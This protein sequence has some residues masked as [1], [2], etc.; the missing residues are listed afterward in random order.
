MKEKLIEFLHSFTVYDYIYLGGV[1]FIFILLIILTL[2]LRTKPALSLF[3]LLLAILDIFLASTLGLD[4]FHNYM[5]K[6]S[7]KVTKAKRL[8]FVEAVVIEGSLKNESKFDFS[9]CK[10][11]AKI[12]KDTHNKY[13]NMIFKLKPIKVESIKLNNIAKDADVKFKFLIEPF[14]YKKDFNVSV[15]GM[16]K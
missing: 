9:T 3:L 1:F 6:N 14:K 8:K 2:L 16:C 10:V 13:K 7:I 5:Y 15:S 11:T 4:L 12:F